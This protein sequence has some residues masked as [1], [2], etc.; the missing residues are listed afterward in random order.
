MKVRNYRNI[1]FISG[2]CYYSKGWQKFEVCA[3]K[4]HVYTIFVQILNAVKLKIRETIENCD[5][6]FRKTNRTLLSRTAR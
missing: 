5:Y 4:D 2:I 3:Y 1:V 6:D